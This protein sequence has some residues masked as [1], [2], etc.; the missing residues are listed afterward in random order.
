M[1]KN[2]ISSPRDKAAT[3]LLEQKAQLQQNI[4]ANDEKQRV[5]LHNKL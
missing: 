1:D 4:L 5:Y 2:A 3:L